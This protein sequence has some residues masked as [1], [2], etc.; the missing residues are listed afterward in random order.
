MHILGEF[1][2]G[3]CKFN[4]PAGQLFLIGWDGM[5]WDDRITQIY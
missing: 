3:C 1:H 2:N 4:S 5:G